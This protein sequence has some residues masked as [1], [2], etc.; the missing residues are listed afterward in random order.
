MYRSGKEYNLNIGI[1]QAAMAQSVKC[2]WYELDE[3]TNLGL[4]PGRDKTFFS[5]PNSADPP[6]SA[7]SLLLKIQRS[8]LLEEESGLGYTS[9]FPHVFMPCTGASVFAF[10]SS[11][12]QMEAT[13]SPVYRRFV[14]GIHCTRWR[15]LLRHCATSRNAAISIPDGVF[16]ICHLHNPSGRTVALVSTQPLTEMSTRSPSWG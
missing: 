15:S 5:S 7:P 8:S 9:T 13:F 2:L 11:L 14:P 10:T 16:E 3:I 1:T 12:R 4:I 6:W